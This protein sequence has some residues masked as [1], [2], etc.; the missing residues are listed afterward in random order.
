MA[1][2]VHPPSLINS[3][4]AEKID[5]LFESTDTSPFLPEMP[6]EIDSLSDIFPNS[7]GRFVV[8]DRMFKMRRSPFPHIKIE[9]MMYYMYNYGD[10]A[11]GDITEMVQLAQDLFDREDESGQDIN[12]WQRSKI[13]PL[14]GFVHLSHGVYKPVYFHCFKIY[15]LE[16]TRNVLSHGTQRTHFGAKMIIEYNYHIPND[17]NSNP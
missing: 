10:R 1:V 15:Q 16:E 8:Y 9:Q 11:V 13:D 3:F 5:L 7:G 17:F 12:E 4:F 14:D 2:I 6:T